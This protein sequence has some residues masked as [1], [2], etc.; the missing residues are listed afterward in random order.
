MTESH[1]GAE[2]EFDLTDIPLD[3]VADLDAWMEAVD[4]ELSQAAA[5]KAAEAAEVNKQYDE[6]PLFG[7]EATARSLRERD[8]ERA[9]ERAA[10]VAKEWERTKARKETSRTQSYRPEPPKDDGAKD[11]IVQCSKYGP[12]HNSR[13]CDQCRMAEHESLLRTSRALELKAEQEFND[14]LTGELTAEEE[15]ALLGRFTL[16]TPD[17]IRARKIKPDIVSGLVGPQGSLNQLNG[18]RGTMKSLLALGLAAAVGGG[19]RDVYTLPVTLHAPVLYVYL[20]GKDGLPQRQRA[21]EAHHDRQMTGVSFLH[22]PVDLKRPADVRALAVL[23]RKI[24]AVLII[25]DSVAKTGGGKED[26]EDFGAYR[27]GLEKLAQASGAAILTLHNSGHDKSRGRGHTTL[28]DGMDSAVLLTRK[29][30]RDGGGVALTDE[31]SRETAGL[32]SIRLKFEPAGPINPLTGKHWSGVVVVQRDEETLGTVLGALS[33]DVERVHT[34]IDAAGGE[35][36]SEQL[37]IALGVDRTNLSR[38]LK[39]LLEGGAL[40]TNGRGTR[41]LRYLRP[42]APEEHEAIGSLSSDAS[43][44]NSP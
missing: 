36:T 30:D 27:T 6:H 35:A 12:G 7:K 39:P 4:Q 32:D 18:H 1:N 14:A 44:E 26:M 5:R 9:R 40:T 43:D 2:F 37:A 34:A 29:S 19:A 8:A 21:W 13:A 28:I 41:A 16:L 10:K 20:E 17:D 22:D 11:A 42:P 15:A 33:E 38:R 24:G 31:K 25:L 23:A 3:T